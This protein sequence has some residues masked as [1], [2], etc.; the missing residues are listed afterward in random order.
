MLYANLRAIDI[1]WNQAAEH[2]LLPNTKLFK[3]QKAI[4]D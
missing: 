2:L 1:L 4:W 3:K